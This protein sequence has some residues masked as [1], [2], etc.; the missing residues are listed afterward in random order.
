MLCLFSQV[1][2]FLGEYFHF[3]QDLF[4]KSSGRFIIMILSFTGYKPLGLQPLLPMKSSMVRNGKS[5]Y[6]YTRL[7]SIDRAMTP[8]KFNLISILPQTFQNR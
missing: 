5:P 4:G 1:F 8:L 2:D 6:N 7:L 3:S